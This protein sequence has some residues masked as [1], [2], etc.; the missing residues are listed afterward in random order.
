MGICNEFVAVADYNHILRSIVIV[1]F[2][3]RY[4]LQKLDGPA[5]IYKVHTMAYKYM[6]KLNGEFIFKGIVINTFS[7]P[8]TYLFAIE[9][10]IW[11]KFRFTTNSSLPP[12]DYAFLHVWRSIF[13]NQM[14]ITTNLDKPEKIIEG[15]GPNANRDLFL[16]R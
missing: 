8:V 2:Q 6:Q 4:V 15:M 10:H 9:I 3:N 1:S 11:W 5:T 12:Y 7:S 13:P 16:R 14:K